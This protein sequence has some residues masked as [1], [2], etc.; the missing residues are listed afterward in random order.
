MKVGVIGTGYVGSVVGACLAEFGHE[1]ICGDNDEEK[2]KAFIIA[3]TD[4]NAKLPI[5]EKG[6]H[7]LIFNSTRNGGLTFTTDLESLVKNSKVIFNAVGTP[8]KEDGSVNLSHVEEVAR[9]I[10]QNLTDYTVIV[11]KSTVPIGTQE[12]ITR[13]IREELDRRNLNIKFDVISNP[14]F[15]K[16]GEAIDDFTKP[17]RIIIG[18]TSQ[19]AEEIMRDLYRT[20]VLSG[21][22]ILVMPPMAAEL[23]K[24][25]SNAALA[26]KITFANQISRIC[27]AI[28]VDFRDVQRGFT[29]DSRIGKQFY[30]AG[31]GYGGSCFPKDVQGLIYITR[32]LGI[33]APFIEQIHEINNQ[34]KAYLAELIKKYYKYNNETLEGKI[35][36]IWG[37]SFKPKTD[38]T[39]EAPSIYIIKYLLERGAKVKAYDPQARLPRDF[40]L[41]TQVDDKYEAI[42]GT[43]GLVLVTEWLEFRAPD[44][45][46]I[47]EI[48]MN[49]VVFDGRIIYS[50]KEVT[51]AGLDYVGIGRPISYRHWKINKK[52]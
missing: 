32:Q 19:R 13:I 39:R 28:G 9:T 46:R 1:V 38:D 45:K 7:E 22:P 51:E 20:L 14:E 52:R 50:P 41:A 3:S 18:T 21:A 40:N 33:S 10:G 11:N 36:G 23:V 4:K 49:P 12:L 25:A 8:P 44:W 34:Q 42:R 17:D 48:M 35:F 15:L 43:H 31:P 16:E 29:S 5:F 24:Y 30:H 2:I 37:I 27:E 26:A 6:L 47:R